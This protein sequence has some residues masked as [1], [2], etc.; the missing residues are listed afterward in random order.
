MPHDFSAFPRDSC[1]KMKILP[2]SAFLSFVRHGWTILLCWRLKIIKFCDFCRLSLVCTLS[3]FYGKFF[4]AHI[5]ASL[6]ADGN[7][8]GAICVWHLR[9]DYIAILCEQFYTT[10]LFCSETV[11]FCFWSSFCA[12]SKFFLLWKALKYTK[13][14][15]IFTLKSVDA[16]WI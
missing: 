14:M 3:R 5:A 12:C 4:N 7:F 9:E 6:E 13:V 15:V 1:M 8:C 16:K 2:L 11:S 10:M